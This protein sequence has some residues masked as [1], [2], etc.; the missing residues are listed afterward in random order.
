MNILAPNYLTL[1]SRSFHNNRLF[2]VGG[3]WRALARIDMERCD[4]PL[5]VLH[6]Y[7][8][9]KSIKEL[10]YFIKDHGLENIAKQCSISANRIMFIPYT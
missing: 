5:R 7:R 6:E 3:S 1:L 10:K 8:M 4:H 9:E 2:L